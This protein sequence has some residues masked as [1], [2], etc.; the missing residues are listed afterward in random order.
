MSN[1]IIVATWPIAGASRIP[2]ESAFLIGPVADAI[3]TAL[4]DDRRTVVK[5][6]DIRPGGKYYCKRLPNQFRQQQCKELG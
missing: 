3:E 5:L 6:E 4:E 1:S 2:A